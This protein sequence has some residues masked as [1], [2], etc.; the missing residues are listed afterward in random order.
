M[1]QVDLNIK[2]MLEDVFFIVV[3]A[4]NADAAATNVRTNGNGFDLNRDNTYKHNQKHKPWR[5][6]FQRG[7]L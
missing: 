6:L 1:E 2:T 5:V 3:P 4:E 7:I